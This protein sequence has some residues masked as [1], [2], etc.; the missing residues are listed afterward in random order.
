MFNGS[1]EGTVMFPGHIVKQWVIQRLVRLGFL[2]PSQAH[3]FL[4]LAVRALHPS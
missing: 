2:M 4:A 1:A 3:G